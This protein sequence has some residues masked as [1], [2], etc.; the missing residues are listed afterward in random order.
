MTRKINE[1]L[2]V[3]DVDGTLLQA[4][5]G[6]P[7]ENIETIEKFAELGGRFTLATGRGISS[8][9]KYTDWINLSAPAILVN[10]GIIY[11][12]N[13]KKVLHEF[14]LDPGVRVVLREIMDVFPQLGVEV[15]IR[16]NIVALRM[17]NE[18]H[19]HTAVEHIPVTLTD[20]ETVGDGWNKVLFADT[21]EMILLVKEYVEK[22]SKHD[23]R[24]KKYDFV[25]TSKIY[26]EL[27]PKGINKAQGLE[28]LAEL[29]GVGMENTVAIGDFYNDIELLGAAG[30]SAVVSDAPD[31]IKETA[32]LIVGPCLGGGVA[33]L[34]NKL[35]SQCDAD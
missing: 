26:F 8:V 19:D 27:I 17:N 16:E 21:P 13:T 11:D 2:V 29:V 20:I 30:L 4:G 33:E 10:G 31:D 32:D 28:K 12:F 24:F 22:R 35:I 34:L 25:Q 14:T 6:I 7:K 15:L 9:G 5:Y 1:L 18:V 23:E 3:S